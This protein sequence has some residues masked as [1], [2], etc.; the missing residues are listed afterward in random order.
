LKREKV[1]LVRKGGLFH[2][3]K[4]KKKKKG[5]GRRSTTKGG[6][7]KGKKKNV[8]G[9]RKN[10]P[11]TSKKGTF[12]VEKKEKKTGGETHGFC[13]DRVGRRFRSGFRREKKEPGKG[14]ALKST[15]KTLG[16]QKPPGGRGNNPVR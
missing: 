6:G 5:T 9:G 7:A 11:T 13:K 8:A 16:L 4:K 10:R 2:T 1:A 3:K 12:H 15:K 14:T